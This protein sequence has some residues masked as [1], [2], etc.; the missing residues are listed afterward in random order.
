MIELAWQSCLSLTVDPMLQCH[1][2][3]IFRSSLFLSRLFSL[4]RGLEIPHK[5]YCLYIIGWLI[6]NSPKTTSRI[7]R[8]PVSLSHMSVS[9][10]SISSTVVADLP[11]CRCLWR[12]DSLAK[13]LVICLVVFYSSDENTNVPVSSVSCLISL[14]TCPG[15]DFCPVST[16]LLNLLVRNSSPF[17]EFFLTSWLS[18]MP[19]LVD[20]WESHHLLRARVHLLRLTHV[21]RVP[22][23]SQM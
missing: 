21:S 22:F 15:S 9:V 20:G 23:A 7:F 16:P 4:P 6:S 2:H 5:S 19:I 12:A 3:R 1:V 8:R 18:L 14:A 10:P 13:K 11:N 17:P